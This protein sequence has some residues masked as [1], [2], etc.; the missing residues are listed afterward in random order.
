RLEHTP[1]GV[2]SAVAQDA[3]GPDEQV[4]LAQGLAGALDDLALGAQHDLAPAA[5]APQGEQHG[6]RG[7]VEVD[8]LLGRVLGH[9]AR[10]RAPPAV[11]A[12]GGG[13]TAWRARPLAPGSSSTTLCASVGAPRP[14]T[15]ATPPAPCSVSVPRASSS[16]RVSTT[17]GVAPLPMASKVRAS[18]AGR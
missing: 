12:T 3:T 5:V 2:G 11:R 16:T 18:T 17:A 14:S 9:P 4:H 8:V 15:T 1:Y 6:G 7:D 13:A 10:V